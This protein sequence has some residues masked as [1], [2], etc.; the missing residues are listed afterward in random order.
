MR[1]RERDA[2]ILL[3]DD[4][5]DDVFL[6]QKAL[7]E[8]RPDKE[9]MR[10]KDGEELLAYLRQQY[11]EPRKG[12]M[13]MAGL[14]LLDLNMPRMDGCEALREIKSDPM[15]RSLPVVVLTTSA[16]DEAVAR[17]YDLG[18]NSFLQKPAD[19]GHLVDALRAVCHY[20]FDIVEIPVDY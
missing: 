14:L 5:D 15:L 10:V 12:Q 11:A 20:W 1:K 18:A 19:F 4:D 16:A 8:T 7:V 6:I 13:P 17:A 3:A 9:F 2:I